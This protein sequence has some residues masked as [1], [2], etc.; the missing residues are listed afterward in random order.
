[1]RIILL[2]TM[3]ACSA[4]CATTGPDAGFRDGFVAAYHRA[5]AAGVAKFYAEDATYVGTAGDIVSGRNQILV[6]L[7]KE[8]PYFRDFGA[9]ASESG[10]NGRLAWER[11]NYRATITVPGRAPQPIY[12]PYLM[13]FERVADGTWR[14]RAHMSGRDRAPPAR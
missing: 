11:G 7:E 3:L 8:V 10:A 2:S 6:G 5:D 14:I 13:V 4:G 1:M 9:V 12:G